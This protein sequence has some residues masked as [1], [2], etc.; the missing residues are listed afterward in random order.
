MKRHL[1]SEKADLRGHAS[2]EPLGVVEPGVVYRHEDHNCQVP[3]A[4]V[5][6]PELFSGSLG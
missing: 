2:H 1:T 5:C 4:E 6:L 3:L